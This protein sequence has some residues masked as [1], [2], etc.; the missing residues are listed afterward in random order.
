MNSL[1]LWW[2]DTLCVPCEDE[3]NDTRKLAISR[4]AETYRN[5]SKVLVFDGE[6]L[7]HSRNAPVLELYMR[8]KLSSWMRRLWTLQEGVLGKDVWFQFSDGPRALSEIDNVLSSGQNRSGEFLYT[9]Y[10]HDSRALFG[11]FVRSSGRVPAE[12]FAGFWKSV[13][14]RSTSHEDDETICLATILGFDPSPIL[15]IPKSDLDK[16]MIQFLCSVKRIPAFILFQEPPRLS[17]VGFRWAPRSFLTCFRNSKMNPYI[18]AEGMAEIGPGQRGLMVVQPGLKMDQKMAGSISIGADFIIDV[19]EEGE[20]R[21]LFRATYIQEDRSTV[22]IDGSKRIQNPAL[23]LGRPLPT[24]DAKTV[25]ITEAALVDLREQKQ[26]SQCGEGEKAVVEDDY[27]ESIF[28]A[29][30]GLEMISNP[31]FISA[32][33]SRGDLAVFSASQIGK[34]QKWL[35]H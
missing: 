11:P 22:N 13:L 24:S 32:V 12:N 16:R 2:C 5:A 10:G 25:L 7:R 35:V 9:R 27:F 6:L 26:P 30:V 19:S 1:E 18:A 14:M 29:V 8:I 34:G 33:E 31:S 15:K 20:A 21:T 4:M 3:H 23:I 17:E 28:L